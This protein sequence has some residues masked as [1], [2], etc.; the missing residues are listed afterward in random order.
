MIGM[1]SSRASGILRLLLF[2]Q[3]ASYLV[4]LVS[5]MPQQISPSSSGGGNNNN[6]NDDDSN[7]SSEIAR[8]YPSDLSYQNVV[9]RYELDH[10]NEDDAERISLDGQSAAAAAAADAPIRLADSGWNNKIDEEK[11]TIMTE[12]VTDQ[13][14]NYFFSASLIKFVQPVR[15]KSV[16]I[17]Y[18]REDV[19]CSCVGRAE[20][21][22]KNKMKVN[23]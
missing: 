2:L 12:L 7:G 22:K 11:Q 4:S 18:T 15:F 20:K 13:D 6:N 19:T 3:L 21:M 23:H 16:R 17:I 5:C 14:F 1:N 10:E 8:K 9:I